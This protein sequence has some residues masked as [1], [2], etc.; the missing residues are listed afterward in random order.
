[1]DKSI[2]EQQLPTNLT[3]LHQ[4]NTHG[5]INWLEDNTDNEDL[6]AMIPIVWKILEWQIQEHPNDLGEMSV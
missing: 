1:M 4:A 2:N 3:F 5:L 6:C